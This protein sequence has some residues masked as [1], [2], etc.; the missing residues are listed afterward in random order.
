MQRL[1]ARKG[2][3]AVRALAQPDLDQTA[4]HQR[5]AD[6]DD[7]QRHHLGI[8]RRFDRQLLERNSDQCRNRYRQQNRQRHRQPRL[9]EKE[10]QHAAQHD[11]LALG[12]IDHI[13][14]VVDQREAQRRQS[15]G[16]ADR[17]AGEQELQELRQHIVSRPL[18]RS[19]VY[20]SPRLAHQ[21]SFDLVGFDDMHL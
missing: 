1:A 8:A 11:E 16:G 10:H 18:L 17:D 12:K 13:A 5:S 14:G 15:V 7:D 9:H 20:H 2:G 3:I 19:P 6:G 21:C 4:N